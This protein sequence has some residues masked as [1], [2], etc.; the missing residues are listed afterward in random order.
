MT[1]SPG[2]PTAPAPRPAEPCPGTRQAPPTG[3]A[4]LF[5]DLDGF[6]EVN[7]RFGHHGGDEALISLSQ[8]LSGSLR[9]SDS[10]ARFGGDEFMMLLEDVETDEKLQ[11]A[12]DRVRAAVTEVPF[13]VGGHPHALD[14]TI[15]VVRAD[16]SHE[17]PDDL[18]R[19]ADA[20]MYHAK[21]LGRGGYAVF[22]RDMREHAA[23]RLRLEAELRAAL[24]AGSCGCSISR[25][26]ARDGPRDR[27]GGPAAL[28]ASRTRAARARRLPGAAVES[29]L[30][31]PIGRWVLHE[32][33]RQAATWQ[34]LALEADTPTVNVNM[35]P[36]ELAQGGL[37]EVVRAAS[38]QAA[39][40]CRCSSS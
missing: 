38:E 20:A 13:V 12:V 9:S 16:E 35:A 21:E 36:S 5:A 25:S 39:P 27:A 37:R 30:I 17:S 7:D 1:R 22:D 31:V 32:A 26:F 18:V 3:L 23:Q 34:A 33:C 14:I 11:R 10:L 24:D 2:F 19:D 29:G 6:K 28:A 4:V 15:G 8:R 40:T